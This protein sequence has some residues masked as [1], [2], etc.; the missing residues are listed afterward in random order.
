MRISPTCIAGWLLIASSAL[1]QAPNTAATKMGAA[2]RAQITQGIQSAKMER[3][4]TNRAKLTVTTKPDVGAK[5]KLIDWTGKE[6]AITRTPDG[7]IEAEVDP[8]RGYL[9]APPSPERQALTKE[10][11]HL[12][13]RYVTFAPSGAV[14]LGGLFL[15]PAV[16]PLTWDEKNRA[17]STEIVVGYEF[18][19]AREIKLPAPKTV[20]FFAEGANADIQK[21]TVTITNSGGLGYQRVVLS[22]GQ[23]D[24]ET[25]FT[26]RGGPGDELKSSVTIQ[27]EPGALRLSL[28]ST[29]LAAFGVGSSLLTVTLVARDGF[30]LAASRPLDI[31]LSSRR[32]HQPAALVLEQGKSTTTADIRTAGF[33]ADQIVAQAGAF[34]A[35]LPIR[36]IFPVAAMVAAFVG[37]AAGGA[38]RYLR[39]KRKRGPLLIRRIA[40]GVLVGVI[41]VGATWAGL[42]SVD[43]S[44]GVLGTPFG[45]FVLGALS[46]YLGC[47]V[48]DRVANKTFGGMKA[49]A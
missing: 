39:N 10:G 8:Q 41:V 36:M 1:A 33:G 21:N 22:T 13:A 44:T 16:I 26:A 47:V 27:R 34:R 11:L 18:E 49:A 12:P 20:T 17:Y 14:N 48:L 37:G 42:V 46:G 32:L 3:L 19:D 43:V 45:A 4:A 31:Q 23:I 40:E 30:P 35:E 6:V 38:A 2:T 15:R 7:L 29:E 9:L 28:P 5:M 24:G 25:R